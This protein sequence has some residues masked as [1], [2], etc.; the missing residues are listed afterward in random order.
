M[1]TLN[2]EGSF[3]G[4]NV[5]VGYATLVNHGAVIPTKLKTVVAAF[6]MYEEAPEV[7]T[8]LF[9]DCEIDVTNNV[10]FYDAAVANKKFWYMLVGRQ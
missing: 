6:G 10:N 5:E 9:C 2:I 4:A 1:A 7:G 3:T 8:Q